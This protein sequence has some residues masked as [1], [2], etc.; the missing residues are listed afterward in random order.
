MMFRAVLSAAAGCLAMVG[1]YA[2]QGASAVP[3]AAL[4]LMPKRA[5]N[6][7]IHIETNL[8]SFKLMPK[9]EEDPSGRLEFTFEGSVLVSNPAPGTYIKTTGPIRKEYEDAKHGKTV[10]FGKGTFLIVG[11]VHNCQWFGENLSLT[12]QGSGFFRV[13]SEYDK[14]LNIGS[15]WFDPTNPKPLWNALRE[16]SVPE[17]AAPTTKAI[18][19][20][21]YEKLHGKKGGG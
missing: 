15:F 11:K 5:P 21:E 2:F 17:P 8:G 13:T 12:F 16:I 18:T 14:D 1:A 6:D 4:A 20:Q 7:T 9:G 19:R 3:A 10:Y